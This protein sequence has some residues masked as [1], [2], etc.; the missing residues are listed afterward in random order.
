MLS[1]L[2]D[3]S[4]RNRLLVLLATA[5][6]V[7][8]GVRAVRTTPVDAIP[9]LSDVQVIIQTEWAE[10]APQIIEDQVTYPLTTALLAVPGATTVRGISGFGISYVYVLFADGTDPYWARS[11]VLEYLSQVREQ[12]PAGASP[13]LG[14]D[15]TGVGWVYQYT[16][17]SDRHDVAELR[18]L[19]DFYVRYQLQSVPGVSEVA[20][21]GGYVQQYQVEVDPQR[22]HG[23]GLSMQQVTNAVRM[24]NA[25][26]GA[27][28]LELSGREYM[29]RGRGYLQSVEDIENVVLAAGMGGTPVRV[30]DVARVQ[31]GPDIRRGVADKNGAGDVVTGIVVMRH[32]ENALAVIDAVKERIEQIRRGLPAGVTVV[33]AYDRAPLIRR[34][35]HNL[36]FK[37]GEELLLVA[38]ITA[39]FLLHLRSSLVAV[40]TLP[41][42][43]LMSFLV[44]RLIGVHA[45]IMSMGGIAI[46]IGA[47][48]DAAVVMVE[49]LHKHLEREGAEP[50]SARRWQIVGEAS[51]E[52]G[53]ALFFSLLV[54]TVSF[55]PVFALEA[56]EG[57]LFKPLAFTKT[58]AMASAAILAVTLTPVAMGYFI[59]GR[60]RSERDNPVSRVLMRGYRPVLAWALRNRALTVGMAVL[61]LLLT[62]IP[63]R[64]LGSEFMPPVEEGTILFMPMTQPGVSIQQAQDIM[65]RQNAVIAGFAEVESVIG[66]AGRATTATDPAPLDMFETVVNL[67]PESEWRTG[68]TYDS[69]V[70]ELDRATRMPGVTNLWTMPIRNRIDMLAT[71]MRTPVGVKVF[72]PDLD[73]LQRLGTELEGLLRQ[74][75]GTRSAVAER[76]A[77]G[78]YLDIEVDRAAA[79]RFGLN[80]MDVQ[81]ALMGALG[82]SIAT[83]TIE[84]RERYGVLVRYPRDFRQSVA[85]VAELRVPVMGGS[86]HVPLGQLATVRL[87]HGP[88]VV[89]TENAFPVS[90]VYV[91]VE[92]RDIGGYVR[93]AQHMLDEQ[94]I[95]PTGYTMQWS[96]QFEAM[97]RVREKLRLV[98]PVTLALIFLLLFLHF[99]NVTQTII[100]MATL[101]FALI[102]GIWL[103]WLLDY[104]TSVAV[105]IGLIA[106]AGVAAETGVVMLVYLDGAFQR[107][108]RE[109]GPDIG[110]ADVYAAVMEGAV[111]R[112]RPKMMTVLSTI[113]GLLPLMWASGA[114]AAT[115][116]RI[117]APMVG[118]LLTSTLLTLI[119]IPVVYAA[120]RE[121]QI[122]R[123][124]FPAVGQEALT[125]SASVLAAPAG[126]GPVRP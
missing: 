62:I 9:D 51:K 112:L 55:L 24:A 64:Q 11:R 96:G 90:A 101:P 5:F 26:V 88:M 118:G 77:S 78:N 82:G 49:N 25:D 105:W 68:L 35:I 10:Q 99:R 30:K 63:L 18:T 74:V 60:I 115:M 126:S 45:N 110:G 114:G 125:G 40:V 119:V 122:R 59:R 52:V 43:I 17:E 3:W 38:L 117:A 83:Q 19:Q 121:S 71:G 33:D 67:K 120:W 8:A 116:Q 20:V 93:D 81:D 79:A 32:G 113:G 123:G 89:K 109:R 41:I 98:L 46:A 22:L 103:L 50:T 104:N 72:G 66:K 58:F 97:V 102:G 1:R 53:P 23:F 34:A 124:H 39:L 57:R 21:V 44:M 2:I 87:N 75:P 69:L 6:V 100:V 12:L 28:V 106:L 84:G 7:A 86:A 37:L 61:V 42:A 94:L 85:A 14:P 73:E 48:I 4:I 65:R 27:R 80:V 31:L 111:D 108:A 70:S 107:R 15:A 36:Q 95:L 91:D 29:V 13:Q 54:I 47:M 16:L 56:Q 92:G 76:G